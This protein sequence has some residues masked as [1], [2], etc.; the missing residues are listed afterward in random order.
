MKLRQSNLEKLKSE[1]FDVLIVGGG[2]NGSV[3]AAALSGK[4]AKVALIDRG[5]FASVTSQESSN[6]AWGGIKYLESYEFGLVWGLCASRNK[7]IRS[8]PSQVKEIRFYTTIAKG[9]RKPRFLIYMGSLLYWAMGRF[10]TEAPRLL[11]RGTIEAEQ[12]IINLDNSVGGLEYSDSYFIDNDARFVFKFIRRC[13][14]QGCVATNY[15]EEVSSKK[16]AADF[17]ITTV[18]D[19]I[20]GEEFEIKSKVVINASGPFADRVNE[21]NSIE[22]ANQHILSKGVHLIVDKIIPERKVLTFFADDGRLFFVIPMGPK[23]CIGTT[24][25]KVKSM[26]PVVTEEDREFILDNINKRLN[27][28]KPITKEDI[29]AERCGVRPLVVKKSN[30]ED[31]GDWVSLSRKHVLEVDRKHKSMT[32]FGGKLTDCINVGEEMV[33]A[34]ADLGVEFPYPTASWYGEPGKEV[35]TLYTSSKIIRA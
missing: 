1:Q 8:F 9:F 11:T 12:P 21:L 2:I 28:S 25:T 16:D 18:K 5:D 35:K 29:I 4:G 13:L 33:D 6:L 15:V 24:D 31:H 7:L 17:W 10:F 23:S 20:S 26:P 19:N 30:N 14:D 34:V 22:T 32:I 3:A 27:L